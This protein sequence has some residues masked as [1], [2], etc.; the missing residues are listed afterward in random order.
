MS[1]STLL[2]YTKTTGHVLAAASVA[3]PPDGDV[4]ATALA[5]ESLL[6]RYLGNPIR[7]D[8]D[9]A[10]ITV[11]SDELLVTAVD[12]AIVLVE[13]ARAH[14]VKVKEKTPFIIDDT[15]AITVPTTSTS[16]GFSVSFVPSSTEPTVV[17][18]RVEPVIP[19]STPA[20]MTQAD[21]IPT[22][23]NQS[24]SVQ[25]PLQN[26]PSGSYWALVLVPGFVPSLS[27]ITV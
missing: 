19:D 2:L 13:Q 14:H 7:P 16:T 26:L 17:W 12:P 10:A 22:G 20:Q 1:A 11:P 25:I 9:T 15:K 3:A 5:G 8:F 23:T 6:I 27:K 24:L 21:A 4:K 18:A